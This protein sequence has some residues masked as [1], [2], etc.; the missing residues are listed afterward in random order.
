MVYF[1]ASEWLIFCST[2]GFITDQVR[3][4]AAD[5][6]R[7]YC[8]VSIHHN[9]VV[10]CF[11]HRIQIMIIHPL[12]VMVLATGNNIADI[13]AL[14][15]VIAVIHHK[16]ISFIHMTFVVTGWCGSFVVHHHFDT[17]ACGITMNL[18]YVEIGIRSDEIE[19][20]IFAVTEPVFPTF[21]PSFY[22]YCIKTV[23]GSE[24][25]ITFYVSGV[26]GMFAVRF[27]FWI[28]CFTQFYTSQLIG[29]GPWAL[30]GY[31]IPPHADIFHRFY[32]R[33]C[34]R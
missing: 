1:V 8:F 23:G 19:Y 21:V 6:C 14:Y 27:G 4:S 31:H 34:I 5:T 2:S 10:C 3:I 33:G 24:I 29:V 28:I 25:D 32:P 11:L 30:S 15:R 16:L 26:S 22:Q 12:S 13:T 18:F 20:I 7:A 17:F 9:L